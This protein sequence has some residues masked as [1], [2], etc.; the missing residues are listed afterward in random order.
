MRKLFVV[1]G[2]RSVVLMHNAA[3]SSLKCNTL[4]MQV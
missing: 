2:I 1:V 3:D 4:I